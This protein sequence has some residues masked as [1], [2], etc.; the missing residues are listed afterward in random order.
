MSN[1]ARSALD[2]KT[3][4]EIIDAIV[5]LDWSTDPVTV[6]LRIIRE[7]FALEEEAAIARFIDFQRRNLMFCRPRWPANNLAET[8][9]R[10]PPMQSRWIRP[11]EPME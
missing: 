3:E 7:R 5:A 8:G 2:P 1:T 6:P 9:E 11:D 10:M 4:G